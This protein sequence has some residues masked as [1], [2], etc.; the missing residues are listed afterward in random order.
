MKIIY[1][2][3]LIWVGMLFSPFITLIGFFGF[4]LLYFTMVIITKHTSQHSPPPPRISKSNLSYYGILVLMFLIIMLLLHWPIFYFTPSKD[5]GP[6]RNTTSIYYVFDKFLVAVQN[7]STI[8]NVGEAEFAFVV[9]DFL[10]SPAL[11]PL[12]IVLFVTSSI[13]IAVIRRKNKEIR[14]VSINLY[15]IYPYE[16]SLVFRYVYC[17]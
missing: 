7:T 9:A 13:L 15:R 2:Q 5:C 10:N 16:C 1:I 8:R 6:F 4:L 14:E 17:R 11:G 12:L 3:C